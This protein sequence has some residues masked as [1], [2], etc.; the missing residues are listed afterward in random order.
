MITGKDKRNLRWLVN[1]THWDG[2]SSEVP[3]G[4]LA[5]KGLLTR[6]K[7]GYKL[8]EAGRRVLEEAK[9]A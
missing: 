2:D 7:D 4:H 8:T 5:R 1:G 9:D 6:T 3:A